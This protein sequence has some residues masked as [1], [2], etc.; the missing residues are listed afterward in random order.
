MAW[1]N[2][3]KRIK[4]ILIAAAI[5]IAAVSLVYS[6]FLVS[7][8]EKEAGNKMSI[9]AEAM[10]SL[11]NADENT[12][13]NLVLK[14]LNT[15]NSIPVV[16]LND[17]GDIEMTRNIDCRD[18]SPNDSIDRIKEAV[19]DMRN[20]GRSI[21]IN[22]TTD[23]AQGDSTVQSQAYMEILYDNSLVLKRL[24]IYPYIQI[25]ILALF[26]III[27]F[28]IVS[29]QR[30]E[31]NR[32]WVGL[33]KETAHQL[34]TPISSLMAWMEILRENYPDDPMLP[35]FG[36]DVDRLNLIAERFSKVGSLPEPKLESVN[37]VVWHVVNYLK[38]RSS[39]SV[40][41]VCNL[42]EP[43]CHVMMNASLFEWVIENLCKNAIDAMEG[44]GRIEISVKD[45]AKRCAIEISDTG[46]GIAKRRFK[47][48]FEP[49]Y[50]T[51]KR[52]WGLGLSLAKRIV[53]KYH[54]GKIFVKSSE[55]GKGTTF[56]IELRKH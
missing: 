37:E 23:E 9:W 24:A 40:K 25:A 2:K 29:S 38:P 48:V 34:G 10:H 53:E 44:K 41:F 12:D 14:I 19:E 20:A 35:E 56:R 15:N 13:L 1:I 6:H 3:T 46:K 49:G 32:V 4:Y 54:K 50:T 36:K 17:A 28:V 45:E 31:Q 11:N 5:V 51:K 42:P 26:A 43:E 21:K 27:V 47:S 22:Y 16:V 18:L 39:A 52:G 33:T 30:A 7:D 8:L 55:L